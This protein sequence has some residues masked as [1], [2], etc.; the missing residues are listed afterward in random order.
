MSKGFAHS[1]LA[2]INLI[3]DNL[4]DRYDNGFP[5]L[6][7]LIQNADDAAATRLDIGGC[8]GLPNVDHPLLR[9]P[10]L[11]VANDGAFTS[12]D[13]KSIRLMGLSSRASEKSTIGKFGLGLKSVF[14]L[15]EAYFYLASECPDTSTS[16]SRQP[17]DNVLNPWSSDDDKP[18]HADWDTFSTTARQRM[19]D[20][21]QAVLTYDP[22]F[23]LWVPLRSKTQ[24]N[25]HPP[26]M[27]HYPGDQANLFA[28][29]AGVDLPTEISN[30]LP[31]LA[32]LEAIRFWEPSSDGSPLQPTMH[33]NVQGQRGTCQ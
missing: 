33:F 1:P 28:F 13:A 19:V 8:R 23:C 14:H 22:W 2:D 31:M 29:L 9:A 18:I 3:R 27:E 5:V 30:V 4:N 12:E 24:L 7:E 10:A 16:A 15:C 17:R 11:F 25:D 20:H 32:H 26:I 6:K 21:L